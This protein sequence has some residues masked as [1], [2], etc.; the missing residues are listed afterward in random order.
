MEGLDQRLLHHGLVR[1]MDNSH[2]IPVEQYI[3]KL[4][5]FK[6]M[7]AQIRQDTYQLSPNVS[8]GRSNLIQYLI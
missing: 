1:L 3:W 4:N 7:P 2:F 8:S 6:W 5:T